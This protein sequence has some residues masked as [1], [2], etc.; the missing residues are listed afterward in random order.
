MLRKKISILYLLLAAICGSAV[1]VFAVKYF[2]AEKNIAGSDVA[3]DAAAN[4][5]ESCEY[6]ISR[7]EGYKYIQPVYMAEPKCESRVFIP[8]KSQVVDFIEQMKTSGEL[9][10]ASVYLK[11]LNTNDWMEIDPTSTYH[12]GSLFKVITMIT[13][14]RMAETDMS[15]LEKDVPFNSSEV[16]PKQTFNSKSITPGKTYKIKELI[17]YMIVYSDNYATM[18]LHRYMN[19]DIFQKTFTD[20]GLQKPDLHDRSYALTVKEYSKFI[21][22]LY[23]G[24][25]LTIPASEFAI[26]LLCESDFK[27]GVTRELPGNIKTAHKFGEAGKPGERELHESAIIYLQGKPYL[28]TIMTKGRDAVKLAEIMSH[29]SKMTYDSMASAT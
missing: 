10:Y 27:M 23:D 15:I 5:T 19:I 14:L 24:G 7:L 28:L 3:T 4:T 26:S 22:V 1:S 9:D 16:P 13:F 20:L 2:D 21:S 8:L 12:P 29:I 6:T 18:L 11:D 25:Y 17:R